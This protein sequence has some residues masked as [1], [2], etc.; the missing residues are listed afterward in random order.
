MQVRISTPIR[1]RAQYLPTLAEIFYWLPSSFFD[2][3]PHLRVR[4]SANHRRCFLS[5][6][7]P[8]AAPAAHIPRGGREERANRRV[9]Q[10]RTT[11]QQCAAQLQSEPL[12]YALLLRRQSLDR[13]PGLVRVS[14]VRHYA[15]RSLAKSV[16][17]LKV[18]TGVY[19]PRTMNV[20]PRSS[21]VKASR[22]PIRWFTLLIVYKL[23][24]SPQ[25]CLSESISLSLC[26]LST[27]SYRSWVPPTALSSAP[28]QPRAFSPGMTRVL[29]PTTHLLGQTILSLDTPT[30]APLP[31]L[32]L[33]LPHIA[34]RST[35]QPH[36]LDGDQ[37]H[38]PTRSLPVKTSSLTT[39]APV[40]DVEADLLSAAIPIDPLGLYTFSPS[41]SPLYSFTVS[42]TTWMMAGGSLGSRPDT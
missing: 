40:Y 18:G 22:R 5:T 14:R 37:G 1:V 33:T 21:P 30:Y 36:A 15:P 23:V 10:A 8:A 38:C 17:Q 34:R 4:Y 12:L 28:C 2:W 35:S 42:N 39:R 32:T 19:I 25:A 20:R 3:P 31:A 29:S 11:R 13:L 16:G 6:V 27:C 9:R 41:S 7:P 26:L 24:I